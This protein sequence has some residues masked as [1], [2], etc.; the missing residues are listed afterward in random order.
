MR[1]DVEAL[2][3]DLGLADE[4]ALGAGFKISDFF[5]E[6]FDA[7]KE[8][9]QAPPPEGA[10]RSAPPQPV[11]PTP[12]AAEPAAPSAPKSASDIA[13]EIKIAQI[14]AAKQYQALRKQIQRLL[15]DLR[16][17]GTVTEV[18][19]VVSILKEMVESLHGHEDYYLF[20]V[21]TVP[22][23]E[24]R[25]D[26][27]LFHSLGVAILSAAM[28]QNLGFQQPGQLLE[29]TLAGLLHDV[30]MLVT[31]PEV[32]TNTEPL[33]ELERKKLIDHP[34]SGYQLLKPFRST[35]HFLDLTVLQVHEREDG[36]GYPNHLHGV[37]IHPYAK[38]IGLCELAESL[39]RPRSWREGH[40]TY[41]MVKTLLS[42][43]REAFDRKLL[44]KFL[45]RITPFPPGVLVRLNTG[46]MGHV[47]H[48]NRDN[49]LR[50][51]VRIETDQRG[52]GLVDLQRSPLLYVVKT[53]KPGEVPQE[54]K[55]ERPVVAAATPP[56]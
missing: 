38:V 17:K 12:V 1:I 24:Y 42:T 14:T 23:E 15:A 13:A 25:T 10:P 48:V 7:S 27:M 35:F 3:D 9:P 28:G 41:D 45:Q 20:R 11:A 54:A 16:E 22:G 18:E 34:I 30:G 40:T 36:S 33:T 39:T 26:P 19:G 51:V 53:F 5:E 52:E 4:E 43:A 50:P 2:R 21:F 55:P 32:W 49:P 56:V 47:V 8:A 31:C 29:L 6:P 37:Q 44:K 46:E